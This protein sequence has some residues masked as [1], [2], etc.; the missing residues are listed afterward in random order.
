MKTSKIK[1][2]QSNLMELRRLR[3]PE[4]YDKEKEKVILDLMSII[5]ES[6]SV[7]ERDFFHKNSALSWPPPV[8]EED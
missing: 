3:N 5:W 4:N 6:M 7:E 8:T 2:Y 1:R